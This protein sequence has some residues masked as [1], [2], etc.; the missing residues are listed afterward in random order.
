MYDYAMEKY[1]AAK[2]YEPDDDLMPTRR[3]LEAESKEIKSL[4]N[5]PTKIKNN[6]YCKTNLKK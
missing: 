3:E 1:E 6:G 2:Y 5:Q 4:I